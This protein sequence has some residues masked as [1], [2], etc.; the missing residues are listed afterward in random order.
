MLFRIILFL[1]NKFI[2]LA[3]L[4]CVMSLLYITIHVDK[5]YCYVILILSRKKKIHKSA[6]ILDFVHLKHGYRMSKLRNS[7]ISYSTIVTKRP[8]RLLE[9]NTNYINI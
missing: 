6:R 3:Q 2:I 8:S 1:R 5:K 7:K 4:L 9:I